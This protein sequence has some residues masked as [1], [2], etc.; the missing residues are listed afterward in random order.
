MNETSTP[1]PAFGRRARNRAQAYPL[2][3]RKTGPAWR[4]MWRALLAE[5]EPMP[6][7]TLRAIGA[8]AGECVETTAKLLLI[9]AANAGVL[10]RTYRDVP[11]RRGPRRHVFYRIADGQR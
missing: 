4:A 6:D 2:G 10:E 11:G 7:E 3:G 9:R 8:A 5:T 1:A